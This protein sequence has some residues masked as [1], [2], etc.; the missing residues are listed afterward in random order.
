MNA[1]QVKQFRTSRRLTQ[2]QA[3]ALIGVSRRCWQAWELGQNTIPK[4]VGMHLNL[5]ASKEENYEKN[6]P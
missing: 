5:L 1:K 2:K 6:K 3:G 4:R